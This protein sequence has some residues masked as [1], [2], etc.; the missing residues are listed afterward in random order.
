MAEKT[1]L[2]T[3][4]RIEWMGGHSGYDRGCDFLGDCSEGWRF[5]DVHRRADALGPLRR[6]YVD[7]RRRA[8]SES[9]SYDTYSYL[10]ERDVERTAAKERPD[11]VHLMY[12][13]KDLG[14]LEDRTRIG[15]SALIGT[16]HQP[17]SWWKMAHGRP[18]VVQS[19]DGLIVLTDREAEFWE[20]FLPGRVWVARHGIDIDFF[21][22]S[23]DTG[24]LSSE[25]RCLVVG[26]WLRDLSTL[27]EVVDILSK[28]NPA[29]GIDIVIPRVVRSFDVLMRLA[30]HDSV[31][32][33]AGLTD[34]EL[35]DLYRQSTLLLLP[36]LAATANNAILE[37]QACGL[38]IVSTDVDGVASY[39]T[40]S[41]ANLFPV[42]EVEGIADA[43]V[44]LV[45]S[46]EERE[47]R[48]RAARNH[49]V[50]HL[51][52]SSLAP[53]ILDAYESVLRRRT[54]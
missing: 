29:I 22:P 53:R 44:R 31:R 35:R 45:E 25:P 36:M 18:E 54:G 49:A 10:L 42:G 17:R 28:R 12:L 7:L 33:L 9:P 38:P 27:A 1:I 52:W 32:F 3:R 46:D 23:D 5:V 4:S 24:T 43:V 13:E 20:G 50:Q 21:C 40:P 26:H 11:L 6:R 19:L 15:G 30:R 2:R 47:E 41:F 14:L 51:S 34:E 48:G 39:V 37:A 16:T 8:C